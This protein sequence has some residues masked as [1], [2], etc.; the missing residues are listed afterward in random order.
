MLPESPISQQGSPLSVSLE[1]FTFSVLSTCLVRACM[2]LSRIWHVHISNWSKAND[3]TPTLKI[4]CDLCHLQRIDAGVDAFTSIRREQDLATAKDRLFAPK[5]ARR[6]GMIVPNTEKMPDSPRNTLKPSRKARIVAALPS[7]IFVSFV[8]AISDR[9]P[10]LFPASRSSLPR[11]ADG[12][13][14]C[15][16]RARG[17]SS[18]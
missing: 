5:T 18:R 10:A 17:R 2:P 4:S 13:N 14:L 1:S 7:C 6:I 9:C 16:R 15:P 12:A 3:S 8:H 11:V